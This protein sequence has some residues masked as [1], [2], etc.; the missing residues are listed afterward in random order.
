MKQKQYNF[1][2]TVKLTFPEFCMW[3]FTF[4]VF[5]QKYNV[6]LI[7]SYRL[8]KS[9]FCVTS[10]LAKF[11]FTFMHLADAFIQSDLQLHSGYTLMFKLM[12]IVL[13]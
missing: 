11:T 7:K 3:Q 2:F 12:F 13:F 6:F 10:Y 5:S 8:C 1:E 4:D 9:G